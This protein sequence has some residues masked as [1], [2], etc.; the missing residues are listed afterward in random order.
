MSGTLKQASTLDTFMLKSVE[1]S[2]VS[3]WLRYV[4]AEIENVS[5]LRYFVAQSNTILENSKLRNSQ[6]LTELID[7]RRAIV[8][9]LLRMS[10]SVLV[11]AVGAAVIV[12][13]RSLTLSVFSIF[14]VAVLVSISASALSI[15]RNRRFASSFK[16]INASLQSSMAADLASVQKLNQS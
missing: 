9:D 7:L 5:D 6:L 15:K 4:R 12:Q 14:A 2:D 1:L 8:T 11:S 10:C 3:N 16:A 13:V